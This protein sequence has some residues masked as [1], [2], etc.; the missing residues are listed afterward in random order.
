MNLARRLATSLA[1][2]DVTDTEL[3]ARVADGELGSLGEIF[4]RHH[5]Q[6]RAFLARM[7]PGS[8]DIDDLVQETF[9]TA[10]RAA[11]SF[12][13]GSSARPF[14]LGIAA[15]LVRR[16]RR[17]FARLRS[18]LERLTFAPIDA[19]PSPEDRCADSQ[20]GAML[21]DAL[22][23]LSDEHREVV[24]L[25]DLGQLSGVD[26]AKALGIPPGTVWRRLHE[27]RSELRDQIQ[28][29]TR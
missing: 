10:S 23:D 9:L 28:R 13:P 29:R 15:R 25:V 12:E 7:M 26:A 1:T 14:L 22:R 4:D 24:L 19:T 6:V 5:A 8:P 18:M 11:P 27:A 17:S 2:D 21:E 16:R 20:R 3:F